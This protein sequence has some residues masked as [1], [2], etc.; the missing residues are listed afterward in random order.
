MADGTPRRPTCRP[1]GSALRL[2]ILLNYPAPAG[3]GTERPGADA[4]TRTLL[5]LA[6][7]TSRRRGPP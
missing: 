1:K 5:R 4:A 6:R 7:S 3:H 2:S